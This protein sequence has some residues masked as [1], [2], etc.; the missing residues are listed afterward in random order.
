MREIDPE[1]AK[2]IRNVAATIL[3]ILLAE[4][5]DERTDSSLPPSIVSVAMI[6][7]SIYVPSSSMARG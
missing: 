2:A 4:C 7:T 5:S 6:V 1:D 3:T